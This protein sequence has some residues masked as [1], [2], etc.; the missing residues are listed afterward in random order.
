MFYKLP[1]LEVP[2]WHLKPENAAKRYAFRGHSHMH[3]AKTKKKIYSQYMIAGTV[4][5]ALIAETVHGFTEK[6]NL[7]K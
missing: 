6:S 4:I 3:I 1:Q 7:W 5:E 2:K